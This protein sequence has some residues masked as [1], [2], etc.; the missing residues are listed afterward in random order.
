MEKEENAKEYAKCYLVGDDNNQIIA[1]IHKY[2]D[3]HDCCYY[4]KGKD[5]VTGIPIILSCHED[6]FS[7]ELTWYG[8]N[9][10]YRL[11]AWSS[12][13]ISKQDALNLLKAMTIEDAQRY[14]QTIK[15]AKKKHREMIKKHVMNI[16]NEKQLVCQENI[17][18][19]TQQMKVRWMSKH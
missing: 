13:S 4:K 6:S 7:D 5:L 12:K 18:M 8:F 14:S 17:E 15:R 9:R 19:K 10:I 3:T 1:E 2:Y 11:G 16:L